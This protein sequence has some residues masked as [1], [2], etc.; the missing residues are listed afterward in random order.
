ML[1]NHLD[2]VPVIIEFE[3]QQKQ[4]IKPAQNPNSFSNNNSS[5]I[6]DRII[7]LNICHQGHQDKSPP[8]GGICVLPLGGFKWKSRPTIKVESAISKKNGMMK[9][10]RMYKQINH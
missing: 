4:R 9:R 8:E 5:S 6:K 7:A 1:L 3:K 2:D 10:L